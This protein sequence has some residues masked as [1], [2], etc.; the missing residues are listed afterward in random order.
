MALQLERAVHCAARPYSHG[1][2]EGF[3]NLQNA[4][5]ASQKG[6]VPT[7]DKLTSILAGAEGNRA[8]VVSVS[9]NT[10]RMHREWLTNRLSCGG[11]AWLL[12][13]IAGDF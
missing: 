4:S 2:R 12:S 6:K 8:F 9:F 13:G 1:N 11:G 7:G 3:W 5:P 10:K